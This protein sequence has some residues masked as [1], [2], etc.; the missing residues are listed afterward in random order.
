LRDDAPDLVDLSLV[1][2]QMESGACTLTLRLWDDK[3]NPVVLLADHLSGKDSFKVVLFSVLG[4]QKRVKK[5][6]IKFERFATVPVAGLD[7]TASDNVLGKLIFTGVKYEV[8][9]WNVSTTTSGACSPVRPSRRW[10]SAP[11]TCASWPV[12]SRR[13]R[14]LTYVSR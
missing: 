11:S 4:E 6:L 1:S 8:L 14:T 13:S 5:L 9:E 12:R 10:H 2:L 7:M 3:E